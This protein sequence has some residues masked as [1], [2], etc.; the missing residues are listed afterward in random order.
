MV[1]LV[2][3]VFRLRQIDG[4]LG[5]MPRYAL[6]R[7]SSDAGYRVSVTRIWD[8]SVDTSEGDVKI[9]AALAVC[10]ASRRAVPSLPPTPAPPAG[11]ATTV[12]VTVVS[13]RGQRISLSRWLREP[14]ASAAHA[15]GTASGRKLCGDVHRRDPPAAAA[16]TEALARS[17]PGSPAGTDPR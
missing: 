14:V 8:T 15:G 5:H 12:T 4:G 1:S 7:V 6:R 3:A 17:R 11:D 13:G 16:A 2:E 10:A 9:A